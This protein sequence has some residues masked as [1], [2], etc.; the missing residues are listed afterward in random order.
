MYNEN[1][2]SSQ[3]AYDKAKKRV[4]QLKGFYWHFFWYLA[5]NIFITVSKVSS[6]LNEGKSFNDSFFEFGTFAI[7]TFWGIGIAFHAMGV[8]GK[9]MIFGQNWE[10]KKVQEYLE[11]E[12][13]Q[14]W[15]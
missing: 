7:W 10:D 12:E 6:D 11:K 5:V 3:E 15:E 9:N 2:Q 8:F 4:K 1:E 13:N 14:K